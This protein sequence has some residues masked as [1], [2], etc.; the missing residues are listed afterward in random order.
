MNEKLKILHF[1]R[2]YGI[3]QGNAFKKLIRSVMQRVNEEKKGYIRK[4]M[5]LF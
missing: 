3:L 5:G 4:P 2:G 1:S